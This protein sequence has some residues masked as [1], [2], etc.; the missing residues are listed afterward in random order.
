MQ[1]HHWLEQYYTPDRKSNYPVGEWTLADRLLVYRGEYLARKAQVEL[2]IWV[3]VKDQFIL[4]SNPKNRRQKTVEVYFGEGSGP[5]PGEGEPV[6]VDFEGGKVSYDRVLGKGPDEKL[7]TVRI[8]DKAPIEVLVLAPDG[9]L[10][11]RNAAADSADEERKERRAAIFD[12]LEKAKSEKKN[13]PKPGGEGLFDP[14][15]PGG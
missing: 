5:D 12:R 11:V 1:I 2:P 7:Q 9:K 8:Q 10:L 15:K 14:R 3:T 13:A 4:A 6:I